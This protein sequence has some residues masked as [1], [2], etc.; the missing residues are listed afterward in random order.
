MQAVWRIV[1]TRIFL[2]DSLAANSSG[3]F[4][5][6][7]RLSEG[8]WCTGTLRCISTLAAAEEAIALMG[9]AITR[10]PLPSEGPPGRSIPAPGSGIIIGS[11]HDGQSI[12]LPAPELSTANS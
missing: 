5:F 3:A 2:S 10:G 12:W 1:V 9:L 4:G 6:S 11:P 7:I 8:V